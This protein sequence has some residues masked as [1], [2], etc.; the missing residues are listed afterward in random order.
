LRL[1]DP[2]LVVILS[3]AA[4]IET[5]VQ[6]HVPAT[7]RER[8]GER[9]REVTRDR[10]REAEREG[11]RARARE[12]RKGRE[13]EIVRLHLQDSLSKTLHSLVPMSLCIATKWSEDDRQ[14]EMCLVLR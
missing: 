6:L 1:L 8:S 13:T 11:D 3:G 10:E 2:L 5:D 9:E 4:I 7:E 12:T 14:E